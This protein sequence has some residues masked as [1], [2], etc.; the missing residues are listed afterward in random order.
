MEEIVSTLQGLLWGALGGAMY[1]A[2]WLISVGQAAGGTAVSTENNNN[3]NFRLLLFCLSMGVGAA[4]GFLVFVWFISDLQTATI[5]K[6]KICV[7]A[8]V[9]GLSG[10]SFLRTLRR[11][12]G[13]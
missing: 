2:Y 12:S 6:E 10:E 1:H 9:A 13:L 11:L 4:A 5:P 8:V 3:K 7:M